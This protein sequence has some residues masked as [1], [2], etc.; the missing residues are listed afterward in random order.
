M[1]IPEVYEMW[2][3]AGWGFVLFGVSFVRCPLGRTISSLLHPTTLLT[4][5]K[6]VAVKV[7]YVFVV[8]KEPCQG[9]CLGGSM[10]LQPVI[11][12]SL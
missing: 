4:G 1:F 7:S 10:T 3:V 8:W 12:L 6:N 5:S 2:P 11:G 9:G